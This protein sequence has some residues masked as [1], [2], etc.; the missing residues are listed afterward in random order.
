ML[1]SA[2]TMAVAL[3]VFGVGMLFLLRPDGVS[4]ARAMRQATRDFLTNGA[5]ISFAFALLIGAAVG[6][7][8]AYLAER[9]AFRMTYP[10]L[11]AL[12]LLLAFALLGVASWLW[13]PRGE[14]V[15]HWADRVKI[16]VANKGPD[17]MYDFKVRF[18]GNERRF[19]DGFAPGIAVEG[20][21]WPAPASIGRPA[22][23][24]IEYE[25][26]DGNPVRLE[27]AERFEVFPA[28]EI[29]LEIGNRKILSEKIT[30]R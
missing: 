16:V 22:S 17:V 20:A 30:R 18:A 21:L 14:R 1:T 24:V 25:D 5:A 27:G 6:A 11:V 15:D 9:P 8:A 7:V 3:L 12:N 29:R 13:P 10:R 19:R 26:E 4:A 23:V 28:G 2:I